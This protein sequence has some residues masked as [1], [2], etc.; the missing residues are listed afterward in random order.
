MKTSPPQLERMRDGIQKGRRPTL[1]HRFEYGAIAAAIGGSRL[2]PDRVVRRMAVAAGRLGYRLGVRRNVVE[3]NLRIAYGERD[4]AWRADI[5]R[6]SYAHLA[7][8]AIATFQCAPGG[9]PAVLEQ[10]WLDG[11]DLL[12]DALDLGR[13]VVLLAGHLG[14]WELGVA[15]ITS[16]GFP[17]DAVARRQNNPLFDRAILNARNRFGIRCIDRDRATRP[18]LESLRSNRILTLLADQDAR[19]AGIFVPFFG[20]LASTPRGPA[21]FKLRTDAPL[22]LMEPVRQPDGRL[23]VRVVP[24]PFEPTGDAEADAYA[25]TAL[26]ARTLERSIRTAP[27]Q[28]LWQHRRWK[29]DPPS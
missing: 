29:T 18:S 28:Y 17:L 10:A 9:Q 1:A 3:H 26:Y 24:V 7:A 11:A 23:R 27:E 20:R 2:L 4:E 15:T 19:G 21:V 16:G 8:E 22:F 14:N 12:S 13:G 6:R 5:A 25:I